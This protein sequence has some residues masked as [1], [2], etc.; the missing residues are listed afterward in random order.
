MEIG[1]RGH[2]NRIRVIGLRWCGNIGK[3][4]LAK[5]SV[6]I[7]RNNLLSFQ[8]KFHRARNLLSGTKQKSRFL[9]S[10]EMTAG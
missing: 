1:K 5:D 9:V 7:A 3:I 8:A 6:K 2:G 10:L 4:S